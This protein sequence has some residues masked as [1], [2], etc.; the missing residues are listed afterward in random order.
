MKRVKVKSHL[1]KKPGSSKK[2]RVQEHTREVKGARKLGVMHKVSAT[3]VDWSSKDEIG[4]LRFFDSKREMDEEAEYLE[5][6]GYD[7]TTGKAMPGMPGKYALIY[8]RQR[9]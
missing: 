2:I 4:S 1:R 7:V 3:S 6:M 8:G 5:G 9:I